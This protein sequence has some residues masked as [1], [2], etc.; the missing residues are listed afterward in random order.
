MQYLS[1]EQ[2]IGD[3]VLEDLELGLLLFA[4]V[5]APKKVLAEEMRARR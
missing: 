4:H 3:Q 2:M 1:V 5:R